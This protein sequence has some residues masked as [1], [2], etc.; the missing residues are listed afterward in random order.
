MS[1]VFE[2]KCYKAAPVFFFLHFGL[3][4]WEWR[5]QQLQ[6]FLL[7]VILHMSVEICENIPI[8]LKSENIT[9]FAWRL[10]AFPGAPP[11]GIESV[12][13]V[14]NNVF[15]TKNVHQFNIQYTLF[16]SREFFVINKELWS[17]MSKTWYEKYG[18]R[19]EYEPR[20]LFFK[21]RRYY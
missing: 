19:H 14:Q 9:Q 5:G 8:F 7:R 12:K 10:Y 20:M 15:F 6:C 2:K 4:A 18:L 3:S 11:V 17:Y 21:F 13:I 1:G 16:L